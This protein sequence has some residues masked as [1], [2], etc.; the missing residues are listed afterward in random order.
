MN[1][2]L[3]TGDRTSSFQQGYITPAII[4]FTQALPD[5]NDPESM[6]LV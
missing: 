4:H 6:V 5:A 3:L 1:R 2:V